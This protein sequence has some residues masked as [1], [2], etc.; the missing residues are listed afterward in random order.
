MRS[1]AQLPEPLLTATRGAARLMAMRHGGTSGMGGL[2]YGYAGL[3]MANREEM[4]RV[5]RS[6]IESVTR[7]YAVPLT[8]R[9]SPVPLRRGNDPAAAGFIAHLV[10]CETSRPEGAIRVVRSSDFPYLLWVP[11][12]DSHGLVIQRL[13]H[14]SGS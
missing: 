10:V 7:S 4:L 11:Q 3:A 5:M 12:G 9:E 13:N 1:D 2:Q 8:L 6:I 14:S